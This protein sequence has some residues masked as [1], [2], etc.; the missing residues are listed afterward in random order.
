LIDKKGP[1][2]PKGFSY[3]RYNAELTAEW[4]GAHGLGH[5][6]PRDVPRLDSTSHMD[7]P[8]EVRRKV[9]QQVLPEHFDGRDAW[10]DVFIHPSPDWPASWRVTSHADNS[11]C[12]SC[13]A[14]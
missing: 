14:P 9:A 8:Q 11:A 7:E 10:M 6:N 3:V 12:S 13:L 2:D 5:I 4:L 1:V